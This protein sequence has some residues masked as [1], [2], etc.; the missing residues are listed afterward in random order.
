MAYV[1]ELT[2]ADLAMYARYAVD[3]ESFDT[4]PNR[5]EIELAFDAA[6]GFV[7]GFTGLDLESCEYPDLSVAVLVVGAEMLDNRQMTEQYTAQNPLVMQILHQHAV[8]Y[9]PSE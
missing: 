5:M 3:R 1:Y 7:A 9:L 2:A 8:N 6:K 4:L